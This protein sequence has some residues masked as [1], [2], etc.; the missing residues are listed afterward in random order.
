M[1]NKSR[2]GKYENSEKSTKKKKFNP[3][4]KEEEEEHHKIALDLLSREFDR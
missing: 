2:Y 3:L 1:T 4:T